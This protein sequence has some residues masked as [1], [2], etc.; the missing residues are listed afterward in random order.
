MNYSSYTDFL[1]AAFP[2]KD[3]PGPATAG[4]T[5]KKGGKLIASSCKVRKVIQEEYG[6]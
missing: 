2:S 6:P 3:F 5:A 1:P 4:N